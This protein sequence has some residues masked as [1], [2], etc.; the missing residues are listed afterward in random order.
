VAGAIAIALL[1]LMLWATR[2]PLPAF[3]FFKKY[4]IIEWRDSG[5]PN[6]KIAVLDGSV[7]AVWK[8]IEAELGKLAQVRSSSISSV[9]GVTSKSYEL[10]TP[11]GAVSVSNR[12]PATGASVTEAF[13]MDNESP[14]PPGQ[15][16]VAYL[17]PKS[18]FE[19]ALD[20]FRGLT[21][22]RSGPSMQ[23]ELP[24]EETQP[25]NSGRLRI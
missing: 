24:V 8:D 3:A 2:S 17:R 18:L 1:G 25:G 23:E 9:N 21:G 16:A 10:Q 19:K 15:C 4:R 14:L 13:S 22:H 11:H 6:V 5:N 7:D 12:V 20:W